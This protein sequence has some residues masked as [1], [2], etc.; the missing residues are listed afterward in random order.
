MAKQTGAKIDPGFIGVPQFKRSTFDP[1]QFTQ[2][3]MGERRATR[4]YE[5]ERQ[6]KERQQ[7]V[8]FL[9][10]QIGE[11]DIQAWEDEQGYKELSQ[12]KQ[13]IYAKALDYSNKGYNLYAPETPQESALMRE[14]Q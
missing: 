7:N 14:F 3:M 6:R 10:E 1:V 9:R 4:A 12:K 13:D 11:V 5:G 8:D 2:R